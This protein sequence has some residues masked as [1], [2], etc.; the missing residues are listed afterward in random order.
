MPRCLQI[1]AEH[2]QEGLWGGCLI[3][4]WILRS[5]GS[6]PAAGEFLAGLASLEIA[7]GKGNRKTQIHFL[8]MLS[9][10]ICAGLTEMLLCRPTSVSVFLQSSHFFLLLY[11]VSL[12]FNMSFKTP[13]AAFNGFPRSS[14]LSCVLFFP[15]LIISMVFP[16]VSASHP[17]QSSLPHC[18]CLSLA[19]HLGSQLFSGP[20]FN[21]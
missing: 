3:P 4:S 11:Q 21:G 7:L 13:S 2:V 5:L 14:L 1:F 20:A 17:L 19:P 16:R 6:S 18:G 9:K 8:P 15:L 10:T 12:Q